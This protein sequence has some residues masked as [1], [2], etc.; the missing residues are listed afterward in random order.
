MYKW[1]K[2]SFFLLPFYPFTFS[3]PFAVGRRMESL[4]CGREVYQEATFLSSW[5]LSV[6]ISSSSTLICCCCF[7][8]ICWQHDPK[9]PAHV[10]KGSCNEQNMVLVATNSWQDDCCLSSVCVSLLLSFAH[11][12]FLLSFLKSKSNSLLCTPVTKFRSWVNRRTE[13]KGQ[14]KGQ[15]DDGFQEDQSWCQSWKGEQL[16]VRFH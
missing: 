13:V 4:A 11:F 5:F 16:L 15:V 6:K 7:L 2:K 9:H 10:W 12:T 14:Y 8:I 1:G 3:P